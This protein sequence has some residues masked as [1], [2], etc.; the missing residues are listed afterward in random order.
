M[1]GVERAEP[2]VIWAR[3]RRPI[4]YCLLVRREKLQSLLVFGEPA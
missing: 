2:D 3:D 1:A 4:T